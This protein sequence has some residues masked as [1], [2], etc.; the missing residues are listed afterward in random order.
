MDVAK[1]V[2]ISVCF[3]VKT[4]SCFFLLLISLRILVTAKRQSTSTDYEAVRES[5]GSI[6]PDDKRIS[7]KVFK[8]YSDSFAQYL[9][10]NMSSNSMDSSSSDSVSDDNNSRNSDVQRHED[11]YES[12]TIILLDSDEDEEANAAMGSTTPATIV[13]PP[14]MVTPATTTTSTTPTRTLSPTLIDNGKF[15]ILLLKRLY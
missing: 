15:F 12:P 3:I 7:S 13:T 14:T 6:S 8:R 9:L 4:F 11:G 1:K 10:E 5:S 2:K